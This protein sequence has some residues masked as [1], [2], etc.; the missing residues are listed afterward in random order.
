MS[1]MGA[2]FVNAEDRSQMVLDV[3]LPA[4]TSLDETSRKSGEIEQE[5]LADPLIRTVFATLGPDGDVNKTSMRILTVPKQKR[6]V[7]LLAIKNKV[8]ALAAEKA[9]GAK[10]VVTDPPFVEGAGTQ[11]AIMILCRGTSYETLAPYAENVGD[12]LRSIPGVTDVQVRYSPGR[13]E[14][15]VE[16][17]RQ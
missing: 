3:E 11:A 7:G 17:D 4:G 5:L 8:R 2:D 9:P 12:V 13:P 14:M 6:T 15:R 1:I 16:I 10:V